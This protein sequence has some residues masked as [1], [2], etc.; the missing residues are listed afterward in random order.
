MKTR[1]EMIKEKSEALAEEWAQ[2]VDVATEVTM[3]RVLFKQVVS[4]CYR[5]GWIDC[6]MYEI[7][8]ILEDFD[9]AELITKGGA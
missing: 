8:L 5:Q 7:G 3:S 9:Q 4:L 6:G 1:D 2:K